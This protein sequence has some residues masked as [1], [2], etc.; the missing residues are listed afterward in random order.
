MAAPILTLQD[1]TYT[2]GGR[3][4]LDGAALSVHPGERL[5]LVGRNGSGKS[6]LLR[7]AA[8]E[9]LADSGKRFLQPGARAFYLSQEPDLSGFETT[10]DYVSAGLEDEDQY[11]ARA[12]LTELGLTGTERTD[13]LSG[14]ENRRCALARALAWQPDLLLLDEPTNHLDLPAITWLEKEL[15]AS[16]AAMIV[17]SHDRRMLETLSQSVVWLDRGTCLLYT[18]P[19]PRD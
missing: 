1:I 17:I 2:L 6:T 15:A 4:L 14:G 12:M 18:S 3:P 16:R 7:I 19:S 8:G 10:F 11:R 13:N 5:C 9:I